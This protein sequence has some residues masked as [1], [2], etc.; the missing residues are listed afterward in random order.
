MLWNYAFWHFPAMIWKSAIFVMICSLCLSLLLSKQQQTQKSKSFSARKTPPREKKMNSIAIFFV[1]APFLVVSGQISNSSIHETGQWAYDPCVLMQFSM[2]FTIDLEEHFNETL[3]VHVPPS[4]KV[5]N[6][7][8]SC[9]DDKKNA[10]QYVTLRWKAI[11]KNDSLE[12]ERHLTI[13]FRKNLTL[14]L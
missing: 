7:S 13:N 2:N 10:D 11:Q 3:V 12:L 6:S 9:G 5:D 1:L 4:A 14:G 8:S